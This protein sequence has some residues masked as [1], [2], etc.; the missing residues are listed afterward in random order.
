[1]CLHVCI[2]KVGRG[3][4]VEVSENYIYVRLNYNK[5]DKIKLCT[6]LEYFREIGL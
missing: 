5:I 1:V 6:D 4:G 2:W 3:G